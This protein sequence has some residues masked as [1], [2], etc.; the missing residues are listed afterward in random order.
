MGVVFKARQVSLDRV[1]ALKMVRAGRFATPDDLQRFRLEAEA[2]AHLD[3]PNIVPIYE[4]GEHEGHH[5]F[6][7]KLVDGGSLAAHVARTR[8][9]R[10]P[11]RCWWRPSPAPFTMR[12]SG[13]S[14]TATSSR[15]TSCWPR[16]RAS[17]RSAGCPWSPTSGW[18]SGSRGRSTPRL[19]QSGSIVGTPGYMAPEQAEGPREA[20][21]TAVDIHALGAILY[22]LLAGRPPFRAGTVLETLRLVREQE[23]ARPRLVNSR[24]D[25]DLET[26]VLKCLEKAPSRRYASAAGP[27]RRP[28]S[29]AGR[30][31]R[32]TPGRRA[33]P[34]GWSSGPGAGRRSPRLLLVA[35]VAVSA[36]ALAIGGLLAW[37]RESGLRH[38]AERRFVR[39]NPGAAAARGGRLFRPDPRG[40]AGP[41]QPRSR[42]GRPAAGGVPVAVAG[43]GVA[44]PDASAAPR[45]SPHPGSHARWSARRISRRNCSNVRCRTDVLPGSVWDDSPDALHSLRASPAGSA[46]RRIH[47][48]DGTAYGLTFDRSGTRLATAGPEGIVKVWNIV[49]GKMTHLIRAHRGLGVGRRLPPGRRAAG[50]D[51]RGRHRPH[52]GRR[53]GERGCRPRC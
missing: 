11:P 31:C 41:G 35:V 46:A 15:R 39:V 12:I 40:R 3:H 34:S 2:A 6:S 32:S 42:S 29:M 9:I 53:A 49:T 36:S 47:G 5:Y 10:D 21:T 51:G 37:N 7:M 38:R 17:R 45:A 30:A 20:I 44:A 19:T 16:G 33:S 50:D 26:I 13:A 1:L 23:P 22:E 43:L 18:P 52:L 14:S 8:P 27:G 48:L 25:R 24:I 28:G 4:V